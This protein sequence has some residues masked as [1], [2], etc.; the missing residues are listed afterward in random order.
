[1]VVEPARLRRIERAVEALR[2]ADACPGVSVGP[3]VGAR[4]PAATKVHR[5]VPVPRPL[6]A[7]SAFASAS[8]S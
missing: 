4:R 3:G 1:M 8:S 6:L 5:V 2:G 7:R